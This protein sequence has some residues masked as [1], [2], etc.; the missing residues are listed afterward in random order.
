MPIWLRKFTFNQLQTHFDKQNE[1]IKK[2]QSKIKSKDT[3]NIDMAN[4]NKVNVPD[5]VKKRPSYSST[6]KRPK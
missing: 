4:T 3:T 6:I 5:F 2:A 1:E